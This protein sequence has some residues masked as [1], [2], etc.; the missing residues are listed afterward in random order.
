MHSHGGDLVEGVEDI[1]LPKSFALESFK[2][3]MNI[4]NVA[5]DYVLSKLSVW[6]IKIAIATN[7]QNFLG[8]VGRKNE[9]SKRRSKV[10]AIRSRDLCKAFLADSVPA[11]RS[12]NQANR[13][14]NSANKA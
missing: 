5:F 11:V 13:P 6:A 10:I 4:L 3:A 2:G 1:N 12:G 9:Y 7:F 8:M 14:T